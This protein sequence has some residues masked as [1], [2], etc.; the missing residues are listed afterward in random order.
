[1]KSGG[2]GRAL[3]AVAA[4]LA[5]LA[6]W[7]MAR[8]EGARSFPGFVVESGTVGAEGGAATGAFFRMAQVNTGSMHAKSHSATLAEL[9]DRTLVAAW[10]AGSGE[11][12]ADVAI[13]LSR[14][15]VDGAWSE[16]AAVMTRERVQAD[17]GV[18]SSDWPK[19]AWSGCVAHPKC[20]HHPRT[21]PASSNSPTI[22]PPR[23][24]QRAD[25]TAPNHPPTI[26]GYREI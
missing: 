14:R 9:P 20:D 24:K 6:P 11:G 26:K 16:P 4:L 2:T 25:P 1:M 8:E 3:L 15:G 19:D 22:A 10:Y 5:G 18:E 12:A 7:W 21:T 17:C 13:Y 23:W